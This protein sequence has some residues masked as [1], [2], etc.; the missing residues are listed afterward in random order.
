MFPNMVEELGAV[1]KKETRVELLLSEEPGL[2]FPAPGSS[3]PD[4]PTGLKAV[5]RG[6]FICPAPLVSVLQQHLS[7]LSSAN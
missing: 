3:H 5:S 6:I 7:A 4:H 2:T 1:H